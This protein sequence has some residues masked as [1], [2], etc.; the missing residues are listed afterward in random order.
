M[1]K[2]QATALMNR[3]VKAYRQDSP[4]FQSIMDD[5]SVNLSDE[6][7]EKLGQ[8]LEEAQKTPPLPEDPKITQ[9]RL[10]ETVKRLRYELEEAEKRLYA[11]YA[12]K[13]SKK[14]QS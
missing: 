12:Q 2:R 8:L 4:A 11:F 3:A 5:A 14:A 1:D 13:Q 9:A 10:E 7:W 6:Q